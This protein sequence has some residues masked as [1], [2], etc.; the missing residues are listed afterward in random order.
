MVPSNCSEQVAH[1]IFRVQRDNFGFFFENESGIRIDNFNIPITK[2]EFT[3][4]TNSKM[5]TK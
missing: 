2:F 1:N 3:N 5:K 4:I